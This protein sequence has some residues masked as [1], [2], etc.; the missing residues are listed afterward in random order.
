[1]VLI[2]S[3]FAQTTKDGKGIRQVHLGITPSKLILATDVLPPVEFSSFSYIP[4][5]DPEIET[6]ELIAIYPVECVNLSIYRRKRRQALKARFCNNKVLYFELGGFEK[7]GMFWNLWC[8]KIK[9]LCPGDSAS[10]RSE[11]SVATSTTGS[12]LYLLDKKIVSVNGMRQLWCKFGPNAVFDTNLISEVFGNSQTSMAGRWT[13]R[14][15]YMGKNFND[16]GVDYRPVINRPA[17]EEFLKKKPIQTSRTVIVASAPQVQPYFQEKGLNIGDTVQI[18]RFG[19]GVN[20][21]CGTGLYLTVDDY[22]IPQRY[23][24]TFNITRSEVSLVQPVN[25]G[26][27]AENAILVWEFYRASDPNKYKYGFAPYPLF[28][29]GYGPWNVPPGCRFSVQVKRASSQVD[30][31]RQPLE[32]GLR[33]S[34]SKRQ[35]LATVSCQYL[36]HEMKIKTSNS[37]PK[38]AKDSYGELQKH[39]KKILNYH[40]ELAKKAGEGFLRKFYTPRMVKDTDEESTDEKYRRNRKR[41]PGFIH[42]MFSSRTQEISSLEPHRQPQETPL[43]YLK[44]TL[45]VDLSVTAWDFDSTTLAEQLTMI[46]KELFLKLSPDELN[47]VVWQQSSKNAPNISALIAFSHRISC[48]VA[49]EVLKDESERVRARLMARFINVADKC[50]RMSNFQSCR[51]VLSGLQSPAMYRLRRTWA[52]IR[53][54]HAS[55]Y[56]I[57][58]YLCRIYRDPR[59]P[60]YQKTFYIMSKNTPYLPYVGDIITKLLNKTPE[61]K[62]QTFRRPISRQSS[63]CTTKSVRS[64]SVET[65]QENEQTQNLFT[66]LL[67]VF[68]SHEADADNKQTN[69]NKIKK[70]TPEHR[71]TIKFKGLHEYFKPLSCYED[72]RLQCIEE[73]TRFLERCQLGAMNYNF[74]INELAKVYLLKSRYKEDKGKFL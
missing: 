66:K 35:L 65:L 55:K 59:T 5:V 42:N 21:G 31:R 69:T 7:R 1:M 37:M 46:D 70:R 28:L 11:T 50:H 16:I 62:I 73:T 58:E 45:K 68:T 4:G 60:T 32:P 49:S 71:K 34:V 39:L 48:L 72:C 19:S 67:K 40:E 52:Y 53:K 25:F 2:E 8:E 47:T 36:N 64:R 56:Q 6:F 51:T 74:S 18:N 15:L 9:F 30:I 12:T 44:R 17:T 41:K 23:S 61:Y 13:D 27:M 22:V 54:K 57:F 38:S 63:F 14:Y 43:A 24:Q 20:E 10:S 29:H 33:L 26:Q 3:P